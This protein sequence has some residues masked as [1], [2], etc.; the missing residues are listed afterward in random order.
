MI[1]VVMVVARL[2]VVMRVVVVP[3]TRFVGRMI[4]LGEVLVTMVGVV[5]V[6]ARL[7]VL[8]RVRVAVRVIV[9]VPVP[10]TKLF[11]VFERHDRTVDMHVVV[12][13]IDEVEGRKERYGAD[14]G[15]GYGLRQVPRATNR[16]QARPTP[17]ATLPDAGRRRTRCRA[18]RW[19][20]R[21]QIATHLS[22]AFPYLRDF[23]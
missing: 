7:V 9:D 11:A 14:E 1:G 3:V 10:M 13:V 5:I 21:W 18:L 6:I 22:D 15:K 20:E 2:V 4:V 23:L 16:Q 8:V 19:A 12:M 17:T